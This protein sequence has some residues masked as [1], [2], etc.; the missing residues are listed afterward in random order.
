MNQVKRIYSYRALTLSKQPHLDPTR[1]AILD[2]TYLSLAASPVHLDT[3][4]QVVE[5]I[6]V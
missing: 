5:R 1:V 4:S 6:R 2:I 3:I